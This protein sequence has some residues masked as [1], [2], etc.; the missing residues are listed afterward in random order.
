MVDAIERE[1]TRCMLRALEHVPT[2]YRDD[3]I[4]Q[5]INDQKWR[6]SMFTALKQVCG[7]TEQDEKK[8]P[9]HT[10]IIDSLRKK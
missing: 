4:Q 9:I 2:Q 7:W 8:R 10:S 3:A 6:T 1:A 5:W